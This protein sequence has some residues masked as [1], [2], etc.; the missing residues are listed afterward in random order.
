MNDKALSLILH[1]F[2]ILALALASM[3]AMAQD[4]NTTSHQVQAGETIYSIASRYGLKTEELIKANPGLT[5]QSLKAG[6]KI[7]IPSTDLFSEGGCREMH[8]VKRKETIWGIAHEYGISL[9]ELVKA[10]PEIAT[11]GYKLKKGSFLCIPY[12]KATPDTTSNPQPTPQPAVAHPLPHL[13]ISII[14]PIKGQG[15]EVKRSIEFTRGFL[16]AVNRMK[17]QGKDISV[18]IHSESSNSEGLTEALS[19][20]ANAGTQL[21]VGP[22]YPKHFGKVARWARDNGAKCLIPFSSKADEVESIP[23]VYLLNAPEQSKALFAANLLQT[24]FNKNTKVVFIQTKGGT[25][26]NFQK[27]MR[28]QIVEKGYETSTLAEGFTYAQLAAELPASGTTI[29]VPDATSLQGATIAAETAKRLRS[30]NPSKPIALMGYPEWQEQ[31]KALRTLLHAANAYVVSNFFYNPYSDLSHAFQNEYK[32]WFNASMLDF[33]PRMA[34]LGYDA[35]INFMTGLSTYGMEYAT[36][37]IDATSYQSD[38]H[39]VKAAEKGGYV[40]DCTL[41]IHYRTDNIIEKISAR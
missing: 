35:G 15:M 9:D 37:S 41:F 25:E 1:S 40:N 3:P 16:M 11:P 22:L 12:A 2:I 27:I 30:A 8:K 21:I 23:N 28:T 31:G 36:Q 24:I 26:R 5:A 6:T 13:T 20:T 10:N 14:L 34:M 18:T 7:T 32:A 19:Q 29:I 38:I 17:R 33:Y 4:D 39:Y